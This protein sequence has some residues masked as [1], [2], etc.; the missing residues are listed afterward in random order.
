MIDVGQSKKAFAPSIFK[1]I[2]SALLAQDQKERIDYLLTNLKEC[3][4]VIPSLPAAPLA[5]SIVKHLQL[6]PSASL[7]EMAKFVLADPKLQEE[8]AE[9]IL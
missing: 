1:A 4:E 2:V 5:E 3:F 7:I 9:D 6:A 8:E